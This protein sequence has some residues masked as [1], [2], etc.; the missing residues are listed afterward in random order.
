[1][2]RL[3]QPRS[4]IPEHVPEELQLIVIALAERTDGEMD[5]HPHP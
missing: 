2:L 1:M 4:V 3:V 5:I